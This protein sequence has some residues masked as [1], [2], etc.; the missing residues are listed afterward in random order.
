MFNYILRRLLVLPVV[1]FLVTAIIFLLILQLPIERRAEVYIPSVNP[2]LTEAQYEELIQATVERYGL[3]EPFYVQYSNWIINLVQ[4]DWGFSP[5]WRQPVLDGL[6]RRLPASI[7]LGVFAMIPSVL[8]AL[9]F[10]R[11]AANKHNRFSAW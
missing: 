8:L 3:N 10:G 4:G 9:I 5:T 11:L 2:H 1:M 7:E 6:M